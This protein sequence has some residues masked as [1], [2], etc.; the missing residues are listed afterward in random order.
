MARV[1]HFEIH[2]DNPERAVAFYRKTLGWEFTKWEGPMEYWLIVTGPDGQPGINGGLLRRHGPI[3]GDS[4]IAYVC[5]VD[6]PSIDE[7]TKRATEAGGQV[8]LPKMPVPG[9]GW[10]ISR[11]RKGTFSG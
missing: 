8:A 10:R 2:A 11:T 1:V 7:Y 6:L 3:N 4:V 5:T 9:I